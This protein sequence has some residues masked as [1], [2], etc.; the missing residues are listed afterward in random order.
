MQ[1]LGV[2]VESPHGSTS[3]SSL[4]ALAT[5]LLD[6]GET[7]TEL[8]VRERNADDT[9]ESILHLVVTKVLTDDKGVGVIVGGEHEVGTDE[10]ASGGAPLAVVHILEPR[11]LVDFNHDVVVALALHRANYGA[12][13]LDGVRG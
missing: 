11:S 9:C 3:E 2:R 6:S 7:L 8:D 10:V 13:I 5:E 1:R 4:G 12:D